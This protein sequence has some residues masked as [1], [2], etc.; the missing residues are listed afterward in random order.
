[1][2][3]TAA[4]EAEGE[5]VS[6]MGFFLLVFDCVKLALYS[7]YFGYQ[8]IQDIKFLLQY[9]IASGGDLFRLLWNLTVMVLNIGNFWLFMTLSSGDDVNDLLRRNELV[10]SQALSSS[11]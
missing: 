5:E 6:S 7:L 8:N 3:D 4:L 2:E 11:Y 10:D 9:G 1:M